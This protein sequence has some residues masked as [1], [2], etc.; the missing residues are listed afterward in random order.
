MTPSVSMSSPVTMPSASPRS[1]RARERATSTTLDVTLCLLL[2]S[3]AVGVL[4]AA[5]P[6]VDDHDPRTASDVVERITT[7]TVAVDY[8]LP[9]GSGRPSG[10][11]DEGA[12]PASARQRT[13]HGTPAAVL[14]RAAV[15]DLAVDGASARPARGAFERAVANRTERAIADVDAT[16][17]VTATYAPLP[18][19]DVRGR[20][21]VGPT[22]PPDVDVTVVRVRVP[23]GGAPSISADGSTNR[24]TVARA[25]EREG[26]AGVARVLADATVDVALPPA[27]ARWAL[28][29]AATAGVVTTRYRALGAALGVTVAGALDAGD[30]RRANDRLADAL[31]DRYERTLRARYD[32]P[33]AAATAT[34]AARTANATGASPLAP[35]PRTV[36]VTV[37]TWSP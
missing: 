37:R 14:A 27:R 20:A 30:A 21:T 33:A 9:A 3:A 26:F 24:S 23:V 4:A 5:G 10:P 12:V 19:S 22:P 1:F 28:R 6:A 32:T 11:L 16:V 13:V 25:A 8:A 2:V 34:S 17:N 36:T 29:D 7:T 31:A 18:G 15:A 35:Q